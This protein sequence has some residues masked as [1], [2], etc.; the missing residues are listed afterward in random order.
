MEI[1]NINRLKA[2]LKQG[3]L[4]AREVFKYVAVQVALLSI[5]S[6]PSP[7][8]APV[9]WAFIAYPLLAFCGIYYCYRR[10]G[11][12]SGR[13]FA[14]RYLAVGWVVGCR[15]G[16]VSVSIF[17]VCFGVSLLTVGSIEWLDD[18]RLADANTMGFLG[19][20]ALIYWRIGWHIGDVHRAVSQ[21]LSP[22]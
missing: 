2:E 22:I 11:G 10:N 1:I 5:I 6:I 19:V 9:D 21:P 4:P 8:D 18:P 14:E 7:A 16:L 15:V 17:A 13:A 3:E 12:A 20:E